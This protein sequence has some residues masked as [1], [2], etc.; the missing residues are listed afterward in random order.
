MKAPMSRNDK[1]KPMNLIP[2]K[3]RLLP[4]SL[5]LVASLMST[6]SITVSAN[7]AIALSGDFSVS[8]GQ[9]S[10][11]L[12]I[13]V[14]P[15]RA[16]HQ[17]NLSFEYRSD[18]PNG[19]LGMGW[20]IGGLS[21]ITRCG[22][23]IEKDGRWGGVAFNDNDRFCLDGQRLIAVTGKDGQNLTEYRLENNGYAK[24]VSFGRQGNGPQH[25]K[26]WYKDGSLLEYGATSNAR[27]QLPDSS[28]VYKW[29]IS[30][31]VDSGK[32]N[33]IS[34][35]YN[36]I[37]VPFSNG[38]TPSVD[39]HTLFSISY[40]GGKVQFNY[41]NRDDVTYQYL[42]G[43]KLVRNK[44]IENVV[45]FDSQNKPINTYHLDYRN[46]P[47]T[48]RS[49]LTK[50]QVCSDST[51]STPI[52]FT[53]Q[54]KKQNS[55]VQ[56]ST[57]VGP[58]FFDKNRDGQFSTYGITKFGRQTYPNRC[59]RNN[60]IVIQGNSIKDLN[61]TVTYG[62]SESYAL[63]GNVTDLSL[64]KESYIWTNYKNFE[65]GSDNNPKPMVTVELDPKTCIDGVYQTVVNGVVQRKSYC[66]KSRKK[67]MVGD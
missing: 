40:T 45:I 49:Q 28:N 36:A 53:W 55:Y 59:S 18:S 58:R 11:S 3:N 38:G 35:S 54:S 66:N 24:V 2:L 19:L 27:A 15:G 56:T 7:E 31:S 65:C 20:S 37:A 44:R 10:Y 48:S 52:N 46:S 1:V 43:G 5:F 51:C 12:P 33:A 32:K 30:R 21:A 39:S 41:E 47:A 23:N 16:G 25:F 22:K 14:A 62:H 17:P 4:I 61:G 26:V 64:R 8:G 13:S 57:I 63:I 42:Y 29:A 67:N 34:Y 9:A 60:R 50:L 6:F